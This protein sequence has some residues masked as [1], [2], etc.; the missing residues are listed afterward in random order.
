MAHGPMLAVV[1][2]GG[3]PEAIIPTVDGD[4]IPLMFGPEGLQAVLPGGRFIKT[5]FVEGAGGRGHDNDIGP[6]S[7]FTRRW[8]RTQAFA[9]GGL[10]SGPLSFPNMSSPAGMPEN[11]V[12]QAVN[13]QVMNVLDSGELFRQGL[14]A[15]SDLV[16][17][18]VAAN[19]R[20]GGV[21][22]KSMQK[23]GR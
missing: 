5:R 23:H 2:E 13:V 15:N 4:A 7:F 1:G 9:N 10:T 21:V 20:N 22:L 12:H 8:N 18:H 11:V 16:L 6:K 19:V 3:R 17:N 14:A